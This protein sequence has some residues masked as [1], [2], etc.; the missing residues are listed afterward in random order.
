MDSTCVQCGKPLVV[1]STGRPKRFCG[2]TCRKR[3][4]RLPKFPA[5]MRD[6]VAWVRADG[7]RPIQPDGRPASST[8]S[9][10]WSSFVDVQSGAGDGFGI[11]L[12]NGLGCYDLDDKSDVF[13]RSFVESV[14]ERIV[15]VERSMSGKG[16]HVFVEAPEARGWKRDGVERYTRSRFIRTTGDLIVL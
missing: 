16:V 12:G 7:K 2:Q 5:V 10:T 1:A 6:R 3:A 13:V 15:F 9:D 4:S 8:N 14:P 11:M